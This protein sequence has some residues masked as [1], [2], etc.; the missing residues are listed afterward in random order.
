MEWRK[1]STLNISTQLQ[2]SIF[3]ALMDYDNR[4]KD[5]SNTFTFLVNTRVE[6]SIVG[7]LLTTLEGEERGGRERECDRGLMIPNLSLRMLV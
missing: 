6:A 5:T 4:N 1:T 2:V 7:L 3:V